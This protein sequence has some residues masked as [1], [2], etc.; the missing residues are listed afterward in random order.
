MKKNCV[1]LFLVAF[2]QQAIITEQETCFAQVMV[3]EFVHECF[4]IHI[5]LIIVD[6]LCSDM[7]VRDISDI[8]VECS[9]SG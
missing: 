5:F 9:V 8:S 3:F 6:I 1:F 2:G 4:V 7:I